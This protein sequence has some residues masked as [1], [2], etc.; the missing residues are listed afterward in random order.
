MSTEIGEHVDIETT[1]NTTGVTAN[2]FGTIAVFTCNATFP[3]RSRSYSNIAE[4]A[5][6]GAAFGFP[7]TK[8]AEYRQVAAALAQKPRPKQVKLIRGLGKPTMQYRVDLL[9]LTVGAT[10]TLP[11]EGGIDA[12]AP[13]DVSYTAKSN[14]VFTA[15]NATELFTSA[16]HGMTTGDGPYRVSNSGGAL[17]TGLAVDTNY[18]IIADVANG[19]AD[20]IN[21]Y[22]L[23]TS[24]ANALAGTEVAITTDGTGTQTL[25][26]AANDVI[27][28]QFVQGINAIASK[29]FT[30]VQVTGAGDTDYVTVTGDAPG[31]W[32]SVGNGKLSLIKIE[33]VHAEPATTIAADMLAITEEDPD[34][35]GVSYPYPSDACVKAMA[36]YCESAESPKI[37]IA[38]MSDTTLATA[39]DGGGD[40]ASD[41]KALARARTAVI[42]HHVP[43]QFAACAW[44]G[45]VLCT[46]AGK[47][48][49]K[50]KLLRGV[51]S[52]DLGTTQ[53]NNLRAKHCNAY[54]TTGPRA[55]TWEGTTADGDFIDII[56]NIDWID[57]R[58]ANR[59]IDAFQTNDIVPFTEKG[60]NIIVNE[61]D[62]TL[63]EA[64]R[65]GILSDDEDDQYT[66]T[67]PLV[68]EVDES[69]RGERT[70]PD[71]GYDGRL[72][73]AIHKAKIRGNVRV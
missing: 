32:F 43:A 17:P 30:A 59:V 48:T 46:E 37:Y 28:A 27:C 71:L 65:R 40:T 39:I 61:M 11:I 60:K 54:R 25:L 10:Y 5:E 20:P 33:V 4:V 70:M 6:D 42:Y 26:R 8:S 1:A 53:R 57:D 50:F 35:Y 36:S 64:T 29:N 2:G 51:V 12:I 62:A 45:R 15:A 21:T 24:K 69:D 13:T 49:W 58:M 3:E 31:V 66:I 67:A 63:S 56:R 19:V 72:A 23:A 47:A 9:A 68:S 44:M 22:Q 34:F 18:W 52:S 55:M 7:G 38:G 73:G 16:A 41:L 14:L